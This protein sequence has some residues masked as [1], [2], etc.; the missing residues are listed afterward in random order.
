M[1]HQNYT[2][3]LPYNIKKPTFNALFSIK[4]WVKTFSD[5]I[6]PKKT[7]CYVAIYELI[8]ACST[9]SSMNTVKQ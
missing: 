1:K 7:S 9:G 8:A 6:H 2:I 4:P 5:S 3:W